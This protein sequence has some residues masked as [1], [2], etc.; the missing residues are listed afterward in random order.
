MFKYL[1]DCTIGFSHGTRY[2]RETGSAVRRWHGFAPL[3]IQELATL[4]AGVDNLPISE[5]SLH[6][7]GGSIIAVKG[8]T[9]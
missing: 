1:V 7:E 8:S 2:Q 6:F 5:R 3:P 9:A 4:P